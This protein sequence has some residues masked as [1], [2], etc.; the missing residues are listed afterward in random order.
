MTLPNS[1]TRIEQYLSE[2]S[3]ALKA[4]SGSSQ[5]AKMYYSIESAQ[6]LYFNEDGSELLHTE[7]VAVGDSG[8]WDG[9]PEKE[10]DEKYEYTFQGWAKEPNKSSVDDDAV[11]NVTST[12]K[13]YAVYKKEGGQAE[14]LTFSS[15]GTFDITGRCWAGP[16]WNGD[17]YYSF[18]GDEWNE[19]DG[20]KIS[21]GIQNGEYVLLMR[22]V[23]NSMVSYYDD[24]DDGGTFYGFK[25]KGEAGVACSGNIELLLDYQTV[26]NGGHPTMGDR[27]FCQTFAVCDLVSAPALPATTLSRGCYQSMFIGC[28]GLTSAPELPASSLTPN[29]YLRMFGGCTGLTA[30]PELPATTLAD[31]CYQ[32]MFERC[33]GLTAAPALPATMLAQGCYKQM[34]DGCTGLTVASAL[35]ATTLA[36]YCYQQMFRSC[37]SLTS[38]SELPAT[39]LA[40][41][42]YQQ[43][44]DG[45]TGLQTIPALPATVLANSCYMNMFKACTGIKLSEEQN[46]EYTTPYRIP[47]S[48]T[49]TIGTSSL[50]G[51][52]DSTGGTFKGT[53]SI[54][55]TYYLANQVVP[56]AG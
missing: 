4:L 51:M 5:S 40:N 3:E 34:F 29:C 21:A 56:A 50:T 45:C 14:Y 10:P 27:C 20:N 32:Q 38:A 26:I 39:T 28:T 46:S 16:I 1:N 15:Q 17:M 44:F 52:F 11:E 6:I 22:G 13:V 43:M 31:S 53:P 41:G 18:D 25:I 19:W 36:N 8:M 12:R 55:T 7:P 48:G 33:T 24:D 9:A 42:C 35:P 2:I 47:E 49:G 37:T 23:G 54:N 30:A